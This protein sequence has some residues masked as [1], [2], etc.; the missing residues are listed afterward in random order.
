MDKCLHKTVYS[1]IATGWGIKDTNIYCSGCKIVLYSHHT[2]QHDQHE[3]CP[4][5]TITDNEW[6]ENIY[7]TC[8][9]SKDNMTIS[10][11]CNSCGQYV[12]HLFTDSATTIKK[13]GK[14]VFFSTEKPKKPN[15]LK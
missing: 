7:K 6:F 4:N 15:S 9:H 1:S 5:E 11:Y 13:I 14:S 2:C 8:T 10:G 3:N 12:K